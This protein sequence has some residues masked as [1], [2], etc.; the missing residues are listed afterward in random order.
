MEK[1]QKQRNDKADRIYDKIRPYVYLSPALITIF[2]L[3]L[4]PILVTVYYAFTNYNL[5]HL[6]DYTLVGL[7]N[8]KDILAGPFTDVF[9]PVF[10]WNIVFA[11]ASTLGC[12]I[13]GLVLAMVLNN[14][15]M[16]ESVIYKGF[17]IIPWALP[18][19]IATLTWQGL[20]NEAHGAINV[21]LMNWHIISEPIKWFSDATPAR[22]GLIIANIWLGFPYMMNI[23][24]GAL[25]SIPETY[26]EAADIDGATP[27]QKFRHITLPSI[28][29]TSLPLLI[30]SFAFNFNNF[31]IAFLIF[32]GGPAKVGSQYA[33]YTD[34]LISS[35]YKMSMQYNMY[36]IGSALA[37]L[38]FLVIGTLSF[39]NLKYTGAFEEV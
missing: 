36:N 38:I 15:N 17:L 25:S 35:T 31:G 7:A 6:E 29:N 5:N 28:T 27:W 19:T 16:K 1:V 4:M 18:A 8:F 30:S 11:I 14:S 34:I 13:V 21:L 3:T 12:F 39:I 26:Y 22:I 24:I 9:L 2:I 10:G 37:L 23:C 32:A 20:F 33:G